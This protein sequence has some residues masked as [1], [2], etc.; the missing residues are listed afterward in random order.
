M[1]RRDGWSAKQE[2]TPP[3][4]SSCCFSLVQIFTTTTAAGGGG[5]GGHMTVV[6]IRSC[7]RGRRGRMMLQGQ[8][9]ITGAAAASEE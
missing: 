8:I 2:M 9:V 3:T 6:E 1:D 7:V 4:I 5:S